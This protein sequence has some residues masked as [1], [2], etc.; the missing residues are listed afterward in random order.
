MIHVGEKVVLRRA[1]FFPPSTP[2]SLSSAPAFAD[3]LF[4]RYALLRRPSFYIAIC[5]S[6]NYLFLISRDFICEACIS[7]SS[8]Y[9]FFSLSCVEKKSHLL[10]PFAI[11]DNVISNI[12][13]SLSLE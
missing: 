9:L 8:C 3:S 10:F 12:S 13:L 2:L 6:F 7:F 1:A 5:F 4:L 11:I